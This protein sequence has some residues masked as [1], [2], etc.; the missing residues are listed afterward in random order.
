MPL[1]NWAPVF[2]WGMLIL[3]MVIVPALLVYGLLKL[4]NKLG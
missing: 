4:A 3:E 1:G 2:V